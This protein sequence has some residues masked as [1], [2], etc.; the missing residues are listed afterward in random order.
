MNENSSQNSIDDVLDDIIIL[1]NK[2]KG[3][4][5]QINKKEVPIT[6]SFNIVNEQ[7]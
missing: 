5:M 2:H 6:P 7:T 3:S 1:Y 4:D